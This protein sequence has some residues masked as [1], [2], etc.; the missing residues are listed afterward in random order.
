MAAIG[1][2]GS[3]FAVI[4]GHGRDFIPAHLT[5]RG[6]TL[7]NLFGIGGA[8]LLQAWSG[9]LF[10]IY[11]SEQSIVSGYQSIFLFFGLFLLLGCLIYLFSKDA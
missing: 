7:L 4:I 8:G 5:G 2:F 6:V 3:S 9:R 1:F 10:T 11:S